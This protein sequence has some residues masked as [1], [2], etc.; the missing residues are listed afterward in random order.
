MEFLEEHLGASRA[1][2]APSIG[3]MGNAIGNSVICRFV[4]ETVE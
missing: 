3:R 4:P 2:L 1:V